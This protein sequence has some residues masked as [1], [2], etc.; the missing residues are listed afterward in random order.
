M[1]RMNVYDAIVPC[2]Q[3]SAASGQGVKADRLGQSAEFQNEDSTEFFGP[4]PHTTKHDTRIFPVRD[5]V[6]R[7]HFNRHRFFKTRSEPDR[8]A[9][10]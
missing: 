10:V 7:L 4:R 1:S 8:I 6:E 5:T 2:W 3:W 9:G